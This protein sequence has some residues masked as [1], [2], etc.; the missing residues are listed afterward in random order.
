VRIVVYVN[1]KRWQTLRGRR[2]RSGKIVLRGLK[3]K[4]GRYRVT[5]VVYGTK[6]YRRITTRV[7]KGCKKGRPRTVRDR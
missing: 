4:R 2:A 3:A 1:G 5:V 7:Y 6:G